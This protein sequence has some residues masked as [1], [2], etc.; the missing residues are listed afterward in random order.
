MRDLLPSDTQKIKYI[1]Q[2]TRNIA[3]LYGYH[4]I[5]TPV[6]ESYELL[7]AKTGDEI[8]SRMY[9][10]NDLGGR[11]VALRPE[12]TASVARLFTS[13][14]RT[15]PKP[16]RLFCTGNLYRYDEPQQGRYR[17][18][19]QSNYEVIGSSNPEAD[20]EV[21]LLT[22]TLCRTLHLKQYRFTFSHMGLLR[23]IL[24]SA[25]LTQNVVTSIMQLLDKKKVQVA[26]D[27]LESERVPPDIL[28]TLQELITIK[29][30]NFSS[31]LPK[32]ESVVEN[33]EGAIVAVKNLNDIL[34][35]VSEQIDSTI[36]FIKAG[37]ARGLEYYTGMIF[38]L[39]I[40]EL[41]IALG[42]GGRYDKLI[43][44]FGGPSTPAVGVAHGIDRIVLATEKQKTSLLLKQVKPIMIIPIQKNTKKTCIKISG[45]LRNVGISV[46]TEIMGRK[47]TKA[48][49]D[50]D[51]RNIKYVILVGEQELRNQEIIVRNL[52]SRE[53]T[54][55]P[56]DKLI[57]F[58]KN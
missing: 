58:L 4:E 11:K 21:I 6:L 39:Y 19:I 8:R 22:D 20:A 54:T 48:L 12:F 17:E 41:K 50:A 49:E 25:N 3:Q 37:F 27:R 33:Y 14:M 5:I 56:I 36:L 16:L 47:I 57:S 26:M 18:F 51:R 46:E 30:N 13:T 28:N 7:S 29:G 42:G 1:E 31:L 35:L 43:E 32:I 34:S 10:F 44:S 53:Q 52:E 2:Q 38:E 55:I 9:T 24:K 23:N 40:P 15:V 45:Q